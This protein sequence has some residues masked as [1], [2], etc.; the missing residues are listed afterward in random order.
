MSCGSDPRL[1]DTSRFGLPELST[2]SGLLEALSTDFV[3]GESK[4]L[5]L[6]SVQGRDP[7]GGDEEDEM[8]AFVQ[9]TGYVGGDVNLRQASVPVADFRLA[10]TPRVFR[11]GGWTDGP[12][13]WI[14]VKAFRVLAV[15]VAGSLRRG[16]PV[17]VIGRLRTSSWER[18]GQTYERL[19]LD[20]VTVGPDLRR[21]MSHFHKNAKPDTPRTDEESDDIDLETGEI[22]GDGART[23]E[24]GDGELGDGELGD[25]EL[26]RELDEQLAGAGAAAG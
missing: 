8:E 12:T 14:T 10:S 24:L 13:T 4:R 25:G 19:E 26:E 23:G 9:M 21:G 3:A 11:D 22:R 16:D 18:D 15:N 6:T 20:A 7:N 2:G 5:G 17:I 1:A